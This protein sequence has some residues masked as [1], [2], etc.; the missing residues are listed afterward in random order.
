MVKSKQ[1]KATLMR[2]RVF[3]QSIVGI[4]P[5]EKDKI[6]YMLA[7]MNSNVI[8]KLLH[9]I[10]P[11]ANN[12]ANYIKQ[13]PYREPGY[14]MLMKINSNVVKILDMNPETDI[15]KIEAV[16]EENNKIFDL[17]YQDIL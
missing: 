15:D 4:F 14:E 13:L 9:I 6:Y 10:N 11:T 1:I 2:N 5:K 8:N 7:L 17:L 12:S 16:N 3:D